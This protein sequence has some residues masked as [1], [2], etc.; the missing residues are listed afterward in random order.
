M[1]SFLANAT[2]FNETQFQHPDLPD[3]WSWGF[4]G[5]FSALFE[6]YHIERN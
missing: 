4:S 2:G 6:I 1:I 3:S 5:T